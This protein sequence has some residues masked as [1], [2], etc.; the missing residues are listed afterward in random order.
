MF[1]KLRIQFIAI[2]MASVAIVLA[3]VFAGIC[4]VE[5]R[6]SADNV[7]EALASAIDRA[8]EGRS[9]FHQGP[10]TLMHANAENSGSNSSEPADDLRSGDDSPKHPEDGGSPKIGKREERTRSIVPV[11]V[12]TITETSTLQ[13]VTG[14]TTASVDENVL[15]SAASRISEIENGQGTFS[16][17]GLHYEKRTVSSTT[18]V[19]FADTSATEGWQSLALNLGIAAL[20]TLAVFLIIS[21][22]LSKWAL[23]PVKDAWDSQRQFVADASHDLKTPLTVILANASILLKH[24]DHSIASESQWI[25]STQTEALHMQGLVNEMLELAQIEEGQSK[26]EA[27][28]EI[29][30]FSD[31]VDGESL[32]FD[33]V[34]LESNCEFECDIESGISVL[35][36]EQQLHKMVSTI[37][38]NAFK[39]VN[40]GGAVN[41]S[42]RRSGKTATLAIRN[43]GS[44]I[45]A[46][47]L[48][49]IFDRFYRTD[50]ART[51][52]AGGF[53]LGL[54]ISREIAR[55]HNGD[56]T[57]ASSENE[58]TTFTVT[59]PIASSK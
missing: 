39:Y 41:V 43:T 37:V 23:R 12:Y 10:K 57:C 19:A 36:N 7:H 47:D 35:G 20:G 16:D 29:V 56:I 6:A 32:M 54:A 15:S 3:V 13:A 51:S 38:E 21:L 26:Q 14:Y 42:L 48:P 44:T 40:E 8:S 31:L 2:V 53:G 5:Y 17:L 11:A 22:F 18:Y 45:S 46:D 24:P 1:R 4:I 50:K 58:G 28:R 25:E 9:G 52:G 30:D 34:A 55:S 33:A 59:L 27:A 49:H